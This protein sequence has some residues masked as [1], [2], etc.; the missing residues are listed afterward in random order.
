MEAERPPTIR[1]SYVS[2]RRPHRT[3]LDLEDVDPKPV[4]DAID[5]RLVGTKCCLI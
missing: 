4:K 1:L 2:I 3:V 5:M